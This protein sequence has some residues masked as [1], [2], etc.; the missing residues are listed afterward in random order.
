MCVCVVGR[1]GGMYE[2]R[3]ERILHERQDSSYLFSVLSKPFTSGGD[4]ISFFPRYC[5]VSL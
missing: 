4:L 3:E 5:C 2:C 1:G